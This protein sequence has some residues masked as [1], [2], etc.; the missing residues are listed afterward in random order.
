MCRCPAARPRDSRPVLRQ[1]HAICRRSGSLSPRLGLSTPA[2]APGIQ[3]QSPSFEA[4]D[5]QM[6]RRRAAVGQLQHRTPKMVTGSL[7]LVR[8]AP[9]AHRCWKCRQA[10]RRRCTAV[11]MRLVAAACKLRPTSA[12]YGIM[13]ANINLGVN[14]NRRRGEFSHA[15]PRD[16]AGQVSRLLRFADVR[17]RFYDVAMIN[18]SR[19][20]VVGGIAR[21]HSRR[22]PA[23][24]V[25]PIGSDHYS[26]RLNNGATIAAR[27]TTSAPPAPR[28]PCSRTVAG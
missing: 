5:L 3:A 15:A 22:P 7:A 4:G 25:A 9:G 23:I 18:R 28:P 1:P 20:S 2:V 27:P 16:R 21:E 24:P 8:D 17:F 6:C 13:P 26:A 14:L 11:I 19:R 12:R 10:D